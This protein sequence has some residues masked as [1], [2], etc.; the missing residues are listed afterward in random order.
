MRRLPRAFV[1]GLAVMVAGCPITP[2]FTTGYVVGKD[3]PVAQRAAPL[4]VRR[5][6][7]A[8]PPRVYTTSGH[9][10]L[11]YVPGVPYVTL[12]Y[13]RLDESVYVLS[14]EVKES[15]ARDM[16]LAPPLETYTY[17]VSIA[18]AIADDL[19]ASGLFTGVAYV[20]D[21]DTAGYR[22]V[23]TGAVRASPLRSTGTPFCLGIVGVLLWT[24][25]IPMQ[26]TTA[27]VAVDLTL[28]DT[29]T[30]AVVWRDTLTSE[31]S[32]IATAYSPNIVYGSA[33]IW[34]FNLLPLQSDVT[35]VD[36]HSLFSWHF[37]SLRRAMQA[38][39][40][41]LAQALAR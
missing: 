21:G 20:G 18:R 5:F 41:S 19:G 29:R 33:G 17:P 6:D 34:S 24:L 9:D 15:G 27:D 32:R 23:L 26:K 4:A 30:G 28:T 38:A 2:T 14:Q 12:S 1:V 11:A 31:V 13:E 16:P 37:E 36:R 40:P 35:T 3:A 10:F 39:K 22:Y 8:R 7:E 25:P